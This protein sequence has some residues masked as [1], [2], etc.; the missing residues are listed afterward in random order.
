M[1]VI[2][3]KDKVWDFKDISSFKI[4]HFGLCPRRLRDKERAYVFSAQPQKEFLQILQMKKLCREIGGPAESLPRT[5]G[6]N[7][8]FF[9]FFCMSK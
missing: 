8:F 2:F 5:Q 1:C 9:F 6:Q 3:F 4:H 7:E